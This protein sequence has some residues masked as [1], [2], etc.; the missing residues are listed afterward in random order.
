VDRAT[1]TADRAGLQV[2]LNDR[3]M[4]DTK[5]SRFSSGPSALQYTAGTVMLRNVRTAQPRAG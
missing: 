1:I 4:V 3:A 5:D 2:T